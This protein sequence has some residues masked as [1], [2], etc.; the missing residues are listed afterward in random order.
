MTFENKEYN[1]QYFKIEILIDLGLCS[2]TVSKP[3]RELTTH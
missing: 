1:I 3:I 2:C